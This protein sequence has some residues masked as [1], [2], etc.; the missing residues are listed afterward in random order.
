MHIWAVAPLGKELQDIVT[1]S[2]WGD[3]A[4][5]HI[6]SIQISKARGALFLGQ[7]RQ[8]SLIT[9]FFL[10]QILFFVPSIV[11]FIGMD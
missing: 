4:P 7:T 3:S 9:V 8:K 2:L 5:V 6:L 10:R 1:G 11:D